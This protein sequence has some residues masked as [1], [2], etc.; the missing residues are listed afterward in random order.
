MET[1][2][3]REN[4]VKLFDAH[5]SGYSLKKLY[6]KSKGKN[7]KIHTKIIYIPERQTLV[8]IT[9]LYV[10]LISNDDL[11]ILGMKFVFNLFQKTD[12]HTI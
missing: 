10:S 3:K 9:Y 5:F 12:S 7:S 8:Q 4:Y 2:S 6:L 11:N 1:K